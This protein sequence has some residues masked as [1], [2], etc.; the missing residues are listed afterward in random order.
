[1]KTISNEEVESK[2]IRIRGQSVFLGTDVSRL[3]GVETKAINQA[4]K[5]N[6]D[7]FP[8]GYVFVLASKEKEEVVK[9][10]YHLK[11][12]VLGYGRHIR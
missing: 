9:N 5:N 7:K 12:R 8:Y 11:K 3:Y 4:V 2:I 6:S 1:M 10:F